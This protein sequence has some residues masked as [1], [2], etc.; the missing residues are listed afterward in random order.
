MACAVVSVSGPASILP[1]LPA[2]VENLKISSSSAQMLVATYS[3]GL[4][5]GLLLFG[6]MKP[7]W[8]STS[9][10]TLAM[11]ICTIA[12]IVAAR[13]DSYWTL[14]CSRFVQ[15]V[16]S[17]AAPALVPAI[18]RSVYSGTRAIRAMA[19]LGSLEAIAP[20]LAPSAAVALLK[21]G[22]WRLP[23]TALAIATGCV[24]LLMFTLW[25]TVRSTVFVVP[26]ISVSRRFGRKNLYWRLALSHALTTSSVLVLVAPV[27]LILSSRFSLGVECYALIQLVSLSSFIIATNV[28]PL[29]NRKCKKSIIIISGTAI[30]FIG[31]VFL[32]MVSY[33]EKLS[34]YYIAI[35]LVIMNI[36][37][38]V[39]GP[40]SYN[41]VLDAAHG[42]EVKGSSILVVLILGITSIGL[43][44]TAPMI[45]YHLTA[46]TLVPATMSGLA[47]F[48][49]LIWP[50]ES[51]DRL[52]KI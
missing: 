46:L 4:V 6:F 22:G 30:V 38:G 41:C 49:S 39:R 50:I 12:A 28:A 52:R 20:A 42:D 31:S 47:F 33:C 32:V 45:E 27:P 19:T 1:I 13:A 36:G 16:A 37:A 14:V 21:F 40:I 48:I 43:V 7:R 2:I 15:G 3:V 51:A 11:S 24:T 35:F 18:M 25:G 9:L 23:L 34:V 8:S 29:M 17:A 26:N 44:F 10:L 5:C